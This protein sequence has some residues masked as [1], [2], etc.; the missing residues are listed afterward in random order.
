[1]INMITPQMETRDNMQGQ[2]GN[3]TR[4]KEILRIK[5]KY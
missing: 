2:M 5:E 1:M 3:E 4:D